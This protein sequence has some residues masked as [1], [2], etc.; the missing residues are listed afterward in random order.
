MRI[1]KRKYGKT[2]YK[3]VIRK[4]GQIIC[5]YGARNTKNMTEEQVRQLCK[6]KY[7]M[8]ASVRVYKRNG[9]WW[10]EYRS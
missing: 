3:A 7:Y 5:H 2:V 10:C 1:C 8:S 9:K 4:N 6:R